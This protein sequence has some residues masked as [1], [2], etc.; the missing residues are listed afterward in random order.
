MMPHVEE[1]TPVQT[2]L[3]RI[4]LNVVE[5]CFWNGL[6]VHGPESRNRRLIPVR[7]VVH[8]TPEQIDG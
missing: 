4:L 8:S 6:T 1:G 2:R 3:Q 7:I 5:R